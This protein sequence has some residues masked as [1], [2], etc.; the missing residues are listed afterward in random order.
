MGAFDPLTKLICLLAYGGFCVVGLILGITGIWYKS[1]V[2]GANDMVMFS[3]IGGGLGMMA[4][5]ALALWSVFKN[6]APFLW[7][8]WLVDVA[9][10]VVITVG[11]VIGIILGMDVR[12]PTR[13]AIDRSFA[14]VTWRE[15][16]WDG[17]YCQSHSSSTHCTTAFDRDATDALA[18]TDR[19]YTVGDTVRHLFGDCQY[20]KLG[21]PCEVSVLAADTQLCSAIDLSVGTDAAQQAACDGVTGG[22]GCVFTPGGTDIPATCSGDNDGS[23]DPATCTG[24]ADVPECTVGAAACPA[25][26]DSTAEDIPPC[27]FVDAD[28]FSGCPDGCVE[29]V[30]TGAE[31]CTGVAVGTP[32]TCTGTADTPVC[33][34]AAVDQAGCATG[35]TFVAQGPGTACALNDASSACAVAGGN[36][37]FSAF[38]PASPKTCTVQPDC[39]KQDSIYASCSTCANDCREALITDVKSGMKPAAIGLIIAFLF[40]V[41]CVTTNHYV[42]THDPEGGIV[43]LLSI[44][45]NVLVAIA[46]LGVAILAAYGQMSI[47]E[48]CPATGDCTNLAAIFAIIL[49]MSL[50]VVGVLG[51][52]GA[53]F[54]VHFF[55]TAVN[56]IHSL[57]AFGL[58]VC[59]TFV[60]IVSGQM[61]TIN[62]KSE[63]HFKEL[64]TQYETQEPGFC[65]TRL[66]NEATGMVTHLPMGDAECRLKMRD[67]IE[68]NMLTLGSALVFISVGFL[69]TM[70]FTWQAIK[71]LKQDDEE[72]DYGDDGDSDA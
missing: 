3:L 5:G 68:D 6:H 47:V 59:G 29:D 60:F 25:G 32:A 4:V 71:M 10:F 1:E 33:D 16:F 30:T 26:C 53:K 56:G 58:L 57:L 18:A 43:I 7:I 8:V 36:C 34:A 50:F 62:G 63:A 70:Y 17:D 49:G 35:C 22:M 64:R 67:Q 55:M 2:P 15:T 42:V 40:S 66:V 28:T 54:G 38:V 11:A 19:N 9:L 61:E 37:A 65:S 24:T 13:E 27:A 69:V 72:E 21:V 46:G 20:A 48:E 51:F 52:I 39:T 41:I 31:S 45:W 14:S 12:D 23:G 44:V